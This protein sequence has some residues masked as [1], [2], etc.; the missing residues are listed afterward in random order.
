MIDL[1]GQL[2]S[3]EKV[4]DEALDTSGCT[5]HLRKPRDPLADPVNPATLQPVDSTV[6]PYASDVPALVMEKEG[7]AGAVVVVKEN[8]ADIRVKDEVVVATARDARMVGREY[9]VDGL[10][11]SAAGIVVVADVSVVRRP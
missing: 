3:A 1:A 7:G 4:V 9:T 10:R 5:V 2:A 11:R 8:A 6:A